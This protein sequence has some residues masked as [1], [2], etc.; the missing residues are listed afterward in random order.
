MTDANDEN[1]QF[2][3]HNV[4]QNAVIPL[5]DAVKVPAGEFLT[6]HGARI[7]SQRRNPAYNSLPIGLACNGFQFL[8]GRFLNANAIS[9]HAVSSP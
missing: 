5:P 9:C 3:H 8:Q 7:L 2:I 6:T 1:G 4:I